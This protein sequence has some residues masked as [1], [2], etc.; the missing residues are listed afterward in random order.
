MKFELRNSILALSISLFMFCDSADNPAGSN[1]PTVDYSLAA[2]ENVRVISPN[3]GEQYTYGDA[4]GCESCSIGDESDG[5][6]TVLR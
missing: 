2:D 6:F 1:V 4:V 3:G 5:G